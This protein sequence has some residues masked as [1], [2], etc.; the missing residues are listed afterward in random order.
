M[1]AFW[2]ALDAPAIRTYYEIALVRTIA[3]AGPAMTGRAVTALVQSP[4]RVFSGAFGVRTCNHVRC[5][6]QPRPG[7]VK[8]S[9][10]Q[11]K[12]L[13]A[14]FK[15]NPPASAR[16][17]AAAESAFGI[18]FPPDYIDFLLECNG[19]EG[20]VGDAGYLHVYHVEELEEIYRD[21]GFGEFAP[22]FVPI[23]TNLGGFAYC[24][25]RQGLSGFY[26]SD[27]CS[28]SERD[29]WYMGESIVELI[30]FIGDGKLGYSAF[31]PE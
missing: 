2:R 5:G 9:F 1:R 26:G 7:G 14:S 10:D 20:T 12:Y 30:K 22:R 23:G 27:F 28:L 17:I 6:T 3:T 4:R 24:L 25:G 21:Y 13:L 16:A 29:S 19:G 15:K 18:R 31:N 11:I 8:L